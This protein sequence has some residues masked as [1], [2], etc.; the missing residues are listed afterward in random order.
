M[1]SL[2]K[3]PQNL[4]LLLLASSSS[5][6]A[7]AASLLP[8]Q[9]VGQ[10]VLRLDDSPTGG[11]GAV[12]CES[13][14]CSQIGIDLLARGGNAVDAWVGTQLCVGVIGMYHSGIGGGGFSLIRDGAGNYT[15]IDYRETAPAAAFED[16]YK[17]NVV[18]SVFGGLA[19]GVPGE[20]RGLGEAHKRFGSLPWKTV[21][22]PAAYVA[23]DGFT[24]TEDMVRYM[25]LVIGYIGWNF[26]VEDP[27]WALDFAPNGTL[28]RLGD[29]MYR[30][31]YA[32]TLMKVAEH[33]ADVFYTGPIADDMIDVIQS[34][35][36]TMTHEDLLTYQPIVRE[37]INITYR[38]YRL[39]SSGAPSSG[40]VCLSTLKTMEGYD[41]S[42]TQSDVNLTLHRF[43]ESMRFAYGA[44][45]ALGD[46]AYL[47][48]LAGFEAEMLDD[49]HTASLRG[50]ILDDRTQPV[51]NYLPP[52]HKHTYAQA[53]HGTS[54]IVAADGEGMAVSSTTTVNILFGNLQMAPSTGI[55]LN[56]EMNDFSIPG[57]RN[58]FGYAPSEANYIRP[59]KRP[60]SSIT[61]VIVERVAAD[62]GTG[63]TLVAVV[64]AAGGSRIISSTTQV[65]WRV[66]EH[67]MSM[68][69]A[70]AEPR[71]HDQLMPNLVAFEFSFDNVTVASMAE[72][73]HNVTWVREGASAVQGIQMLGDGRFEAVG[74][75]RQKNSA[76]LTL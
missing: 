43:D 15:V 74:E 27:S 51:E 38:G 1:K 57:I 2:K 66:L 46:P 70:I 28:L 8:W 13:K 24:V 37:A 41:D 16:M 40:A 34:T 48:D 5:P 54:H 33:G 62:E 71:L 44:H 19:A 56:N 45:Q 73:G 76:G 29:T 20:L 3:L 60:L 55:I 11:R 30:K 14:V 75:T 21:V 7:T 31:R 22:Q 68:R 9:P 26:L 63:G 65:V 6:T 69:D 52:G 67:D 23:R 42:E 39:F 49:A 64:G 18:G 35:N 17:D 59:G 47:P 10:S 61:P 72:K 36:G 12:A 32:A 53:S 58:E 50:R 4:V 25:N